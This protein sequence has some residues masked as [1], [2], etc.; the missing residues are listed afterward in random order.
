MVPFS[1]LQFFMAGFAPLTSRGAQSFRA[2]SFPELTQQIFDP[3]NS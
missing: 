2:V 1:R 3:K